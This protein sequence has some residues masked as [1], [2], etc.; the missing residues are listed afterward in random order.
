MEG[1]L[2]IGLLIVAAVVVFLIVFEYRSKR[3]VLDSVDKK[4]DEPHFSSEKHEPSYEEE[5]KSSHT[6]Y[7]FNDL[8]ILNVMAQPGQ[9]FESYDL[10]QAISSAGLHFGDMNIFHYYLTTPTK[11]ITLFSLASA[12]EPGDFD[13]D[14]IG[15]FSCAG[16]TLFMNVGDVPDPMK[17]FELMLITAQQL[18]DD[19]G[20]ELRAGQKQV[21]SPELLQQY[22]Q[23]VLYSKSREE[24]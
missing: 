14:H 1:Y 6:S 15:D 20:G 12:T 2:R 4:M 11:K 13:M 19:L 10:I 21:W 5:P 22:R 17:S 7:R 8:I 16:L 23:R 24:V 18:A 9:F 3:R